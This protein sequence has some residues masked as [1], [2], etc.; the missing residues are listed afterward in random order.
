M[1]DPG[2]VAV[3]VP[4]VGD[5]L[6]PTGDAVVGAGQAP[7]GQAHPG[8]VEAVLELLG[9]GAQARAPAVVL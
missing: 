2:V 6:G 7:G 1:T 3:P 5:L 4:H 9:D 8:R